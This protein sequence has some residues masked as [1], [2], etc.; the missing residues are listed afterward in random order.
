MQR[1]LC[2]L[3]RVSHG[4]KLLSSVQQ[5]DRHPCHTVS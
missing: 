3:P 1:F 4:E 5:C 2:L